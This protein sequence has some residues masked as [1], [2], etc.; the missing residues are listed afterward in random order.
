MGDRRQ[1]PAIDRDD[2]VPHDMFRSL[3][4]MAYDQ[5]REARGGSTCEDSGPAPFDP[6]AAIADIQSRIKR[7]YGS[8]VL[9]RL[10]L[11]AIGEGIADAESGQEPRY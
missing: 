1:D 5:T 7:G 6:G 9:G 2:H 8:T 11:V 4:R 3:Y 10:A